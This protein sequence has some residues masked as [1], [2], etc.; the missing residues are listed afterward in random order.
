MID[1]LI[2]NDNRFREQFS[3][4]LSNY[5]NTNLTVRIVSKIYIGLQFNF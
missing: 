4:E 2:I 5:L 1:V 3:T